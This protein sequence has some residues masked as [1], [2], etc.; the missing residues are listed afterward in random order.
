MKQVNYGTLV[1]YEL[2]KFRHHNRPKSQNRNPLIC[3]L[4]Q[5]PPFQLEIPGSNVPI[6]SVTLTKHEDGQTM[7]IFSDMEDA[8]FYSI[9]DTDEDYGTRTIWIV[10]RHIIDG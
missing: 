8:G 10:P 9:Q 6:L 1:F 4:Q 5:L 7:L 3:P 2:E